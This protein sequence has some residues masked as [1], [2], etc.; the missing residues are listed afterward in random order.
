MKVYIERI[1]D[2]N[3]EELYSFFDE[4]FSQEK[5]ELK[6]NKPEV[7]VKPNL[8]GAH[9][10]EKGITTHPVVLEALISLLQEKG[11]KPVVGDSPGGTV[12]IEEVWE[13]TGMAELADKFGVGLLKFGKQGVTRIKDGDFELLLDT[14]VLTYPAIINVAKYKTHSLTMFT[15]AVKNLFGIVPGLVKSDYHRYYPH[16]DDL[17]ALL[18]A[19]YNQ[20]K[21]RVVLNIIDGIIGMEGEGPSSGQSRNFGVMMASCSASALDYT[22]AG[23]MGYQSL[24]VPTVKLSLDSDNLKPENIEIDSE[25]QD[26][27]F[28][29]TKI[30]VPSLSSKFI[31][32]MPNF[33]QQ[34][35]YRLYDYYPDFNDNCR[36]CGICVD[37]CPVKAITLKKGD[38]TPVIDHKICIK[39]MCCQEFCPYKAV[40]L[41]KTFLAKLLMGR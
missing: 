36:R 25:W 5:L 19:V 38:L 40:A 2:Y 16:P 37:S 30:G 32:L 28:K 22:A 12:R 15:G 10:P 17:A 21:D 31:N 33:M 18:V 8:L 29:G 39:C 4:L 27:V 13:K 24:K 11:Y 20:I 1:P 14:T 26:Y 34:V 23:M 7:L 41:K 3:L 35:F 9:H 6:L